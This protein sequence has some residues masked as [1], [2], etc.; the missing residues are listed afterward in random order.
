MTFNEYQIEAYKTALLKSRC[1]AYMIPG[2]SGETGEIAGKY[3]KYIRGDMTY[4]QLEERIRAEIGDGLWFLAGLATLIGDN[5]EQIAEENIK[6][7]QDRRLRGKIQGDGDH[8]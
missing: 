4:E 2:L 8:R 6:K 5:L 7:L 1:L 3:A